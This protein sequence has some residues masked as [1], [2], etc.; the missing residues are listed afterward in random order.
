MVFY[1]IIENHSSSVMDTMT[2]SERVTVTDLLVD[3]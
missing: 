2:V 3:Q 1:E